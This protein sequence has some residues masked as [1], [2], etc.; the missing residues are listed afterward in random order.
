MRPKTIA[1]IAVLSSALWLSAGC[2][3]PTP[4][5]RAE[6]IGEY[7]NWGQGFGEKR[8]N[9]TESNLIPGAAPKAPTDD[10]KPTGGAPSAGASATPNQPNPMAGAQFTGGDAKLGKGV[11]V[12]MCARCH[13]MT[14]EGGALPGG[15]TVPALKDKTWQQGIT[16]DAMASKIAHGKGAMPAFMGQLQKAQLQGVVAFIRTLK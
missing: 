13:G 1:G 3:Q 11:W 16:D 10:G 2:S 9:P 15:A 7:P 8:N 14:G 6:P 12:S 5:A 4:T